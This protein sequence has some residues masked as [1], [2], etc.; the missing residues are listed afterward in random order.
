MLDAE[1]SMKATGMKA[2]LFFLERHSC[3]QELVPRSE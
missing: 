2:I 3:K 1:I